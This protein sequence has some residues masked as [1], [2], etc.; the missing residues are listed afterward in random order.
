MAREQVRSVGLRLPSLMLTDDRCYEKCRFCFCRYPFLLTADAK[1][2]IIKIDARAQ[3][4]EQVRILSES[5]MHS[6][7]VLTP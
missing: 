5:C 7:N 4:G 6:F 2:D 3:M 1:S